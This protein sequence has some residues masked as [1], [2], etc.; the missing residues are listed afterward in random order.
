MT[1][2]KEIRKKVIL[3]GDASVGKTSLIRKFVVD[4]FDDKY[5]TTIGTK[6]TVKEL[7]LTVDGEMIYLKFQIW[8]ILGQKGYKNLHKTSFRGTDGVFMV[9]DITRKNTLRSLETYWIPEVKNIVGSI[10]FLILTNKS[11]LIKNAEFKEKELK[12]FAS[13]YKV[14]FYLTSARSGENVKRAFD[15]LGNILLTSKDSKP[16][17]PSE[18]WVIEEEKNE[19]VNL[20]DRI[21]DDFCMEYGELEEAMPVLRKQIMSAGLDLN[22]PKKDAL[23]RVIE[24][25]GD[26]EMGFK[27]KEIAMANFSKRLK[28]IKESKVDG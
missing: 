20:I 15:T 17:T 5:I 8:D 25:L 24:K 16:A 28:W 4:K 2:I 26:V 3:L 23:I 1:N 9:A 10:P 14:P 6:I 12:Q 13:K 7:Q 11:D 18:Y 19:M 27:R 21:I 22:K